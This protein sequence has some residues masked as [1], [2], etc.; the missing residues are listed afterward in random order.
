MTSDTEKTHKED[1]KDGWKDGQPGKESLTEEMT[2]YYLMHELCE[3]RRIER[4]NFSLPVLL[5][6]VEIIEA[7]KNSCQCV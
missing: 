5:T 2:T 7:F 3:T 1:S 6:C 4:F